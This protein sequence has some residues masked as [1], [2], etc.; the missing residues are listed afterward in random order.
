MLTRCLV[1]DLTRG[2]RIVR[3]EERTDDKLS[4]FNAPDGRANLFDHA[5]ILMP[6]RH[7]LGKFLNAAVRPKIGSANTA[8]RH[9]DDRVRLVDDSWV[10]AFLETHIARA[11]QNCAFHVL[12]L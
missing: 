12:F 2:T 6:H 8:C 7:G 5:A 10:A 1:P 3:R 4:A 11:I 9:T